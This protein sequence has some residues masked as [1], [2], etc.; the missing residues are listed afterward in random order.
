MST[1]PAKRETIL[2]AAEV[3]FSQYGF[4]RTSMD[5]I[6]RQAE[7][8]RASIYSYFDNK[9]AVFRSLS[10]ALCIESLETASRDMH[11]GRD[12]V[13]IVDRF[14]AG[15]C[16]FKARLYG[17]LEATPHGVEIMEANGRLNADIVQDYLEK[18]EALLADEL[19]YGVNAGEID[20]KKA[21]ATVPET[22]QLMH[23]AA[24]GLK[25]GAEDFADFQV[26]LKRFLPLFFA[27]LVRLV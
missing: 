2:H 3:Q 6:A 22:A 1:P 12:S 24:A 25:Q 20:L 14:Y 10:E 7:I 15:L 9:E 13:D 5:D 11:G 26:K 16:A 19:E 18:I 23:L 17:M 4:K 21:G 27:G 8:S